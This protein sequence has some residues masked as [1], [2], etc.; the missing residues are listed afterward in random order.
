MA[1]ANKHE[2]FSKWIKEQIEKA[3]NLRKASR[4]AGLVHGT[5]IRAMA[6]EDLSLNTLEA[7]AKWTGVPLSNVL[8]IYAGT[9]APGR[10]VELELVFLFG[11]YPELRGVLEVAVENL[12]AEGLRD[13][14]RYIEFQAQKRREQR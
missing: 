5:L 10:E 11:K 3:G 2:K 8:D 1:E 6:G 14:M 9:E 13:V 4:D 12:D 7:I